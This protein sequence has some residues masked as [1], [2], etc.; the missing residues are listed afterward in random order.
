[1]LIYANPTIIQLP[2]GVPE[3]LTLSNSTSTP[4]QIDIIVGRALIRRATGE[5]VL[6]TRT[7]LLKKNL[8]APWAA[9][10]TSN[11]LPS[12]VPLTA[13]TIYHV[14]LIIDT[15]GVV[16]AY[17]DTSELA[18]NRPSGWDAR[19]IG[20]ILTN[21]ISVIADFDQQDDRFEYRVDLGAADTSNLS[22]FSSNIV[23]L[24]A[25]SV[26]SA[27]GTVVTFVSAGTGTVVISAEGGGTVGSNWLTAVPSFLQQYWQIS[28]NRMR[29]YCSNGVT[30]I[31]VAVRIRGFIH[32][33]GAQG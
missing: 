4:G 6:A 22:T 3:G 5:R 15:N 28:G 23:T 31:T 25:P 21:P 26:A 32:P 16:D 18:A 7:F 8:L 1:M 12:N 9:G 2:L 17:F 24:P 29:L 30:N 27:F 14:F 11:G 20:S 33:R 19:M 13:N 10:F